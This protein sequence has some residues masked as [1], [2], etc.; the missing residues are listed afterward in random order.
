MWATIAFLA[1]FGGLLL[2]SHKQGRQSQKGKVAAS[3]LKKI[4]DVQDVLNT[5]S[6]DPKLRLR[7]QRGR[8]KPDDS[9]SSPETPHVR[10]PSD[11]SDDA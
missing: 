7:K 5:D 4:N 10:G 11:R 2:W 3:D 9:V 1:L 8:W 6:P